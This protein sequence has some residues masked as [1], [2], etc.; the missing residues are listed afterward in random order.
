MTAVVVAVVLLPN[1]ALGQDLP[2]G[3]LQAKL[4][5]GDRI[6]ILGATGAVTTGRFD[7]LAPGS[8]LLNVKGKAVT[9]PNNEVFQVQVR[10]KEGDGVLI[11]L[12]IGAAAGLAFVQ[13]ECRDAS[14]HRDCVSVGRLI[15]GIPMAI[16]GALFDLGFKRY[17]TVF[18]RTPPG[19]TVGIAPL[20]GER[21]KGVALTISF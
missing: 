16:V 3:D 8:I 13:H 4:R 18:R 5:E 1:T 14:E 21:R 6:R 20:I 11:G 9:I 2:L 15:V 17:D 10:R 19:H 7:S 12:G